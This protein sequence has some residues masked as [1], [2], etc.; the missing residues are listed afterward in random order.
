MINPIIVGGQ[1]AR[2]IPILG[3]S[4]IKIKTNDSI[5]EASA[6]T[7]SMISD[8]GIRFIIKLNFRANRS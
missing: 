5:I 3:S 7:N 4:K 8:V 6:H 2:T 1:N